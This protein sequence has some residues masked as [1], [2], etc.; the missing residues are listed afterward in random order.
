MPKAPARA[1]AAGHAPPRRR[2]S[3]ARRSAIHIAARS[4]GPTCLC[5]AS[6][7]RRPKARSSRALP[8]EPVEAADEC[9]V[10]RT[11]LDRRGR[12]P[13]HPTADSTQ[14]PFLVACDDLPTSV[15]APSLIPP[16][17]LQP[18]GPGCDSTPTSALTV[19]GND[20]AHVPSSARLI[21]DHE[22]GPCSPPTRCGSCARWPTGP[23]R[24]TGS[25]PR[26]SRFSATS[27]RPRVRSRRVTRWLR[28]CTPFRSRRGRRTRAWSEWHPPTASRRWGAEK[29]VD[30]GNVGNSFIGQKLRGLL[31][32]GEG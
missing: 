3:C 5:R 10:G 6:R 15:F 30:P 29:G 32:P 16:P 24:A 11:Y 2:S 21:E 23:A 25:R 22:P 8:A 7:V 31:A 19:D 28:G 4:R 1:G 14:S 13:L 9:E 27:S 26:S 17:R 20:H 18:H 12:P